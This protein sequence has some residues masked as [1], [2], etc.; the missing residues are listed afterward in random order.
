[1]SMT[2][3]LF[4]NADADSVEGQWPSVE[5]TV[6]EAW[7]RIY[8]AQ[9]DDD[10][11]DDDDDDA[12]DD[13]DDSGDGDSSEDDADDDDD[14][15]SRAAYEKLRKRMQAADKAKAAAE[16]ALREA[17]RA[18]QDGNQIEQIQSD[19]EEANNALQSER[20]AN[21]SLR[22]QVAFL[23]NNTHDWH[24]PADAMDIVMRSEDID[25]DDDGE[26]TGMDLA[27][28]ALAK[29]KP[30]MIKTVAKQSDSDDDEDDDDEDDEDSPPIRRRSGGAQSGK[31]RKPTVDTKR[32]LQT[33]P[34]LNRR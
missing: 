19:L 8:G 28:K 11:D 31:R 2:S 22:L 14:K 21:K 17:Q 5:E 13:N 7:S 10:D 26:V 23:L 24:D 32:L 25:I 29:K 12:D 15:V 30:W 16:K 34:A 20:E 33:Y 3:G 9:P 18:G 6:S 4:S 27:I 1:M